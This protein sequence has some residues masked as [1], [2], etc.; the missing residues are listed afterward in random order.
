MK[1]GIDSMVDDRELL[2]RRWDFV[3]IGTG[4]GGATLG[5]A[6]AKAGRSVLFLERGRSHSRASDALTG[7]WLESLVTRRVPARGSRDRDAKSAAK[8]AV[9]IPR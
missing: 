7:D 6:L 2:L 4:M 8:Q 3:V 9:E 1:L 5:Y